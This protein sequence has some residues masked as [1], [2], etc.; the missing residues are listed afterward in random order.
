MHYFCNKCS[1]WEYA[2]IYLFRIYSFY[3]AYLKVH[4]IEK[5]VNIHVQE[6]RH[7]Q[8]FSVFVNTH[9]DLRLLQAL[10][11][12][13]LSSQGRSAV[14]RQRVL[15]WLNLLQKPVLLSSC[16]ALVRGYRPSTP[17]TSKRLA[18]A[19]LMGLR[20]CLNELNA[21]LDCHSNDLLGNKSVWRA[22][23]ANRS[24]ILT[25]QWH[26]TLTHV[27]E[28]DSRCLSIFE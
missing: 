6:L 1:F 8:M 25:E 10:N 23:T 5:K 9:R 11:Q 14:E 7:P 13:Y 15:R 18:S 20:Q 24:V 21:R 27:K 22:D 3:S 16:G 26:M 17:P 19:S 28:P 12:S 2:K 4:L